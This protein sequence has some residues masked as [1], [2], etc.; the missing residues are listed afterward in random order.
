MAAW[1]RHLLHCPSTQGCRRAA[2]RRCGRKP[3]LTE[4]NSAFA[5]ALGESLPPQAARAVVRNKSTAS[6][7]AG[8]MGMV[9]RTF[10]FP[11]LTAISLTK[12]PANALR[13][14]DFQRQRRVGGVLR[15]GSVVD[16]DVLV[17]EHRQD[18]SVIGCGDA[19]AAVRDHTLGPAGARLFKERG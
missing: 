14:V 6:K 1:S 13:S 17:A 12:I 16:C 18:E 4:A 5:D 7:A 19:A 11:R 3:A 2:P 15:Q 9:W 8:C 10:A